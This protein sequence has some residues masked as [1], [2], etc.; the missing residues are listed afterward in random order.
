MRT[1]DMSKLVPLDKQ[2]TPSEYAKM[3][4]E[5]GL[6]PKSPEFQKKMMA[7]V[8]AKRTGT[9]KGAGTTLV[10]PGDKSFDAIPKFRKDVQETLARQSSAVAAADNVLSLMDAAMT[11]NNPSAFSAARTQLAK[12]AGDSQISLKEIEAAGGDPSIAGKIMNK[13]SELFTG[14]PSMGTM[15]DMVKAAEILRKVAANRARAEI[16]RQRKLGTLSKYTPEQLDA[17]LD[18]PEFADVPARTYGKSGAKPKSSPQ[19]RL[20]IEKYLNPKAQ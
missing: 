1:G 5:S 8:D 10:M 15:Q 2:M 12:A 19:D 17:A 20:L 11:G 9:A 14:T 16:A 3:L 6:D 13:T 18:F 4:M 7:Y